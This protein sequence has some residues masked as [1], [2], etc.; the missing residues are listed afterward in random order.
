[1]PLEGQENAHM[2]CFFQ[3]LAV[4]TPKVFGNGAP[5]PSDEA[6]QILVC[7]A[8]AINLRQN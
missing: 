6:A 8:L 3:R 7:V 1:M 2:V 4:P 5:T